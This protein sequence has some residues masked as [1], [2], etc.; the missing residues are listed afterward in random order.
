MNGRFN[1]YDGAHSSA[2]ED[3]LCEIF[4]V[5]R[6]QLLGILNRENFC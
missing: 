5:A 3:S 1:D 6:I 2:K 4:A